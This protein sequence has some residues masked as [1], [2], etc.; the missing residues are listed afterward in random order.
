MR[1]IIAALLASAALTFGA[2]ATC[3]DFDDAVNFGTEWL[4][5]DDIDFTALYIYSN[6]E[7]VG[8]LPGIYEAITGQPLPYEGPFDAAILVMLPEGHVVDDLPQNA[9]HI[10]FYV[11]GC[12][13]DHITHVFVEPAYSGMSSQHSSG[14]QWE[15]LAQWR[16]YGRFSV[17]APGAQPRTGA[18]ATGE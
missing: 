17:I 15:S 3:T 1:T 8:Y 12:F 16:L 7:Y 2:Q 9:V 5:D 13:V 10:D 18:S 11:D 6:P 4:Y 14:F